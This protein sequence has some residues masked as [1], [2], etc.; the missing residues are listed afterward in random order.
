M[1]IENN[2]I[3]LNGCHDC[4]FKQINYNDYAVGYDT[5]EYCKLCELMG[6]IDYI[7]EIY[8]SFKKDKDTETP[9]WCPLKNNELTIK[10]K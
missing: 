6:N 4:P 5:I 2:T 7:L 9:I 3:L 10:F 8:D 1:K